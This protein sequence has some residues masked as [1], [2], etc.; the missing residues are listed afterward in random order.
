[1]K[2]THHHVHPRRLQVATPLATLDGD[3]SRARDAPRAG[4]LSFLL[5]LRIG[6]DAS[7][8]RK[9]TA[10]AA[11]RLERR[12]ASGTSTHGSGVPESIL[13]NRAGGRF[14]RLTG[15]AAGASGD[16]PRRATSVPPRAADRVRIGG[17][18]LAAALSSGG[19]RGLAVL[20]SFVPYQGDQ[21]QTHKNFSQKL[22]PSI[23][24]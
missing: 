13:R 9:G 7:G 15:R 22:R 3:A 16:A 19:T 17:S 23:R 12:A 18:R 4:S 2:E 1:M 24:V 20:T 14:L 8:S 5:G 6:A 10:F 21:E 11:F